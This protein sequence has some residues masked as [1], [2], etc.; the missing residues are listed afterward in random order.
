MSDRLNLWC[1]RADSAEVNL[2]DHNDLEA[3][4]RVFAN[5]Q[6]LNV[7]GSP[8]M[9]ARCRAEWER[10]ESLDPD[11][12]KSSAVTWVEQPSFPGQAAEWAQK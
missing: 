5:Q 3:A 8:E 6:V 9:L 2:C 1:E 10:L 11:I 12:Q 7:Y 4:I